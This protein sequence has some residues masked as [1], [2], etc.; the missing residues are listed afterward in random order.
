MKKVIIKLSGI[1]LSGVLLIGQL[2]ANT[3]CLAEF[4]QPQ[5]PAELKR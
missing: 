1:F 3:V 2:T 5:V 4:Y